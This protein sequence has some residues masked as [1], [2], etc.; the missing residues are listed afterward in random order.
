MKTLVVFYSLEGN[1]KYIAETIA[2][3]LQADLLELK[4]KKEY[5]SQGFKK[6]FWGGKS[7]I[8]KECPELLNQRTDLSAYQN[9]VIG[10]PIWAG[11]Y[12]APVHSFL[13]Q[14]HFENKKV[15][16][17]ACHGGGGAEKCFA[18]L[19]KELDNNVFVGEKTFLDPL[20]HDR[21]K[22]AMDAVQWS[23]TLD[24]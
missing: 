19:K 17:F 21:E 20:K 8:F 24:F 16:L 11:T 10:T 14:N 6:F 18:R 2:K 1:T 23:M 9:I 13:E 5:P 7:V 12:S 22:N 15:A 4:P 3:Q